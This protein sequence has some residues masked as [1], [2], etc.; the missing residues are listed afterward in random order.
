M[1]CVARLSTASP[2]WPVPGTI[3]HRAGLFV[4]ETASRRM[5]CGIRSGRLVSNGLG[6]EVGRLAQLERVGRLIGLDACCGTCLPFASRWDS[7]GSGTALIGLPA[8]RSTASPF[9]PRQ[10]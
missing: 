9:T 6:W 1:T 2:S 7:L 4:A 3:S 5:V 10:P 8:C